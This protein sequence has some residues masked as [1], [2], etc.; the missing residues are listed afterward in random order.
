MS[1]PGQWW[2][3]TRVQSYSEMNFFLSLQNP[4]TVE[5]CPE[6]EYDV[7]TCRSSAMFQHERWG[8]NQVKTLVTLGNKPVITEFS[9]FWYANHIHLIFDWNVHNVYL[10]PSIFAFLLIVFISS[11]FSICYS[12][13]FSYSSYSSSSPNISSSFALSDWNCYH[14][15]I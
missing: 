3:D 14:R 9:V 5:K 1:R 6:L 10:T 12:S 7:D 11:Y 2:I 13:S 8:I 15:P 4:N